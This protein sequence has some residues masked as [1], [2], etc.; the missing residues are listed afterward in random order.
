MALEP[1]SVARTTVN[2]GKYSLS[3]DEEG[4]ITDGQGNSKRSVGSG[5]TVRLSPGE[6]LF[7]F[8]K[9]FRFQFDLS[10]ENG[11]TN[12]ITLLIKTVNPLRLKLRAN[13]EDV[14]IDD[15]QEKVL[16]KENL[17]TLRQMLKRD[18]TLLEE[19]IS[20]LFPIE[21]YGLLIYGVTIVV[22][23]HS[24][25]DEP[26][27]TSN[28]TVHGVTST[29]MSFTFKNIH[30]KATLNI[31]NKLLVGARDT[32]RGLGYVPRCYSQFCTDPAEN[33]VLEMVLEFFDEIA[34]EYNFSNNQYAEMVSQYVQSL[35]Y[36]DERARDKKRAVFKPIQ[37]L[38]AGSGV[39]SDK[40]VLLCSLL[41]RRN[42]KTAFITFG[43][44][45][46]AVAAIAVDGPGYRHTGYIPIETT[47]I[48]PIGYVSS[49]MK[50][51][52]I[53]TPI[54]KGKR[55]YEVER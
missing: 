14:T 13:G 35:P 15:L 9:T 54:G 29:E 23:N 26:V 53:L 21:E 42:Y 50:T 45:N 16:T 4:I 40:A 6:G 27:L 30:I 7:L 22:H 25:E 51:I 3:H 12:C 11:T 34:K 24:S 36:D 31:P 10:Q 2:I 38:S 47:A 52:P 18:K 39:C 37:T 44:E 55:I 49:E 41:E 28:Q 48:R 43:H 17:A 32:P 20:E 5:E 46:H 8:R 33:E 19:K 1:T